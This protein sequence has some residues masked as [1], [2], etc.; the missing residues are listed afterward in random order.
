MALNEAK[1]KYILKQLNSNIV[2]TSP[3]A[4]Q[5]SVTGSKLALQ[6][7]K[8]GESQLNFLKNF[9]FNIF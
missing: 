4:L 2:P 1:K 3:P 7:N 6:T 5:L 9:H 8:R